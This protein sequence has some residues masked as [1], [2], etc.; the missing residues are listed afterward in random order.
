MRNRT[1]TTVAVLVTTGAVA[2]AGCSSSK[3][4]N[5]G[6]GLGGGSSSTSGGSSNQTYTLG[7]IGALSGPN[8]QLG[9][10]EKQG[11]Q[12]AID[13]ANQSGKF[14][15][16]V[17]LNPQDSEGDPAK[18]PA[19]ATALISNPA[20]I[21]VIGPAF[22]GE[23]KA[24]DPNF[25]SA[26]LP[27]VTASAS[28]ATLQTKG[29]SC[30][31]RIIPNDDVEGTQGAD[32][33]A[34][35]G[36]KKVFVLNDLSTYGQGVATKMAAELK[37]KGV[38]T[39]TQG[40]DGTTTKN[41]NPIAQTIKA[42]GADAIFY[43]GY[44]AQAALLAKALK[45]AGFTGRTV[46][47]NGGK[48][49]VFTKNASDAGNGWYFTCGCQDATTAP[50]AKAF[51]TAYQAAYKQPPST[52]SPEAF[53]A[54]NLFIDAISK[55]AASGPVTKSSLM[56]A[57]NAENFQGITTTIKFQSNGEVE[58]TN[59]IVNLFQQKSGAITGLGNINKI[60]S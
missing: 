6:G 31:H 30:W 3:K 56:T 55:A 47:G 18:A 13:Q 44:D 40:L 14:N 39:V 26:G 43:G 8:A 5:N 19:A 35:T 28:N 42:S 10:N 1:L 17:A 34:R 49:D 25:C 45:A 4:S 33:L 50:T 51:A 32:W 60:N 23:S 58:A 27:I 57:L 24:V 12:L 2:L 7:F 11:A 21:G 41:Y 59:L 16:K 29:Y 9:I 36:A 37:A 48:S 15:F 46:T 53:D 22:S 38:A 20:V 52:Y 54:A